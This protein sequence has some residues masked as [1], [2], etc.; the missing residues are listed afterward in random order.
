MH[1]RY[2]RLSIA[3][4]LGALLGGAAVMPVSAQEATYPTRNCPRTEAMWPGDRHRG[5]MISS[6]SDEWLAGR[7]EVRPCKSLDI[8]EPSA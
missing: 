8:P 5:V 6:P 2:R 3:L 7:W 1:A 4:V